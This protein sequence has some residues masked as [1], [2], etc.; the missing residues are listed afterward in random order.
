VTKVAKQW[1]A[2]YNAKDPAKLA[3]LYAEDGTLNPP[4]QAAVRGRAA[5]QNW[6]KEMMG[7]F[8]SMTLAPSESAI[9]GNIAYEAGTYVGTMASGSDRG[10]YVV[11]L[12]RMGGQWLI[13]HDI[14]NSD[15]PPPP[16]ASR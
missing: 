9:S 13:A 11:V 5:I 3:M 8:T 6:A 7:V 14:F 2:A 16:P 12:K 1:E 15:M 4:N 10:K